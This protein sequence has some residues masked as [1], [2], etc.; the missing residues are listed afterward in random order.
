MSDDD[1]KAIEARHP[2]M[3][4]GNYVG[5]CLLCDLAALVAEVRRLRADRDLLDDVM[6]VL[7]WSTQRD[8]IRDTTYEPLV[9]SVCQGVG[10]GALMDAAQRC[11]RRSAERRG[12]PPGG[13]HVAG[14][15][16]GT[17][18]AWLRAYDA[19]PGR[20][21]GKGHGAEGV[22]VAI[23]DDRTTREQEEDSDD[24]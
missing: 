2:A 14:P 6:T 24:E 5:H 12:D 15:C 1:I 9:E 20:P 22:V 4:S 16:R 17:V 19:T 21:A 10:Y 23:D 13:E 18:D 8:G 7:R 3:C 11:W